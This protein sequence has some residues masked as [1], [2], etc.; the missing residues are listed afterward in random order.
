MK[1]EAVLITGCSSG[2]GFE[3]ALVLAG[4]GFQ[5]YATMRDL[6]KS[7]ALKAEADRRR[8]HLECLQ[9]DV[10]VPE[11]IKRAVDAVVGRSGGLY[12]LVNNAGINIRGF[13][14]DLSQEEMHSVFSVNVFG[15]MAATRAVLP[16]MRAQGRGRIVMMSS[17]GGKLPAL[18]SSAYCA[19]KFALEGFAQTLAQEV[20]P[21]GVRVSVIEPG[22]VHTELFGRNRQMALRAA[23]PNSPYRDWFLRLEDMTDRLVRSPPA[24]TT[25][26]AEAVLRALAAERPRMTYVVG[27]RTKALI[28]LR[29]HLPGDLFDR[30]WM[31][32]AARRIQK[33][34]S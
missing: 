6:A 23:E 20:E 30:I 28:S 2:I 1:N 12:G 11:S 5:V 4:R 26:V 29:R 16:T 33:I 8:L 32:E 22:F 7:D 9:L 21:F 3:T 27:G 24:S 10:T 13:F 14:E 15:T 25:E 31:R 17:I 19:S 34:K 18:G